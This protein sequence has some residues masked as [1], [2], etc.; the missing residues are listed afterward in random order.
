MNRVPMYPIPLPINRPP[1]P[2]TSGPVDFGKI[3]HE[4][5][6]HDRWV[7]WRKE[8]RR[9]GDT[10]TKI[11]Y[12]ATTLRRASSTDP[13]TWSSYATVKTALAMHKGRFAGLGF[14]LDDDAEFVG[15][16][17]DACRDPITGAIGSRA[18]QI[19]DRL[20]TYA[21]VSP[22]GCGVK[23]IGSGTMPTV[24]GTGKNYRKNPWGTGSGG[25]EFYRRGRFF[26]ITG[27]HLTGT[28]VSINPVSAALASL[29]R[30]LYPPLPARPQPLRNHRL[31]DDN[32]VRRCSS[33][34]NRLP[35]SVAGAGGHN[36]LLTAACVC[37]RFGLNDA[38]AMEL[39]RTYNDRAMPPWD[40]ADVARKLSEAHKLIGASFGSM[41][42]DRVSHPPSHH[43][44]TAQWRTYAVIGGAA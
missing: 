19:I 13:A 31:A 32:T 30:E 36:A 28:P 33:Y 10:P 29:Y 23:L 24:D 44:V 17:L 42:G 20:N 16:D 11:P 8:C 14:V 9:D 35:A 21:E 5:R 38:D 39:L 3:P 22:S 15:I 12:S 4:L 7:L 27:C 6:Q 40:D 37:L 18:Q 41:A 34:L 1:Q 26:T 43:P 2:A 25:V